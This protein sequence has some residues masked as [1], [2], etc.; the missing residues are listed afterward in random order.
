MKNLTNSVE[1]LLYGYEPG[2]YLPI[3]VNGKLTNKR[4]FVAYKVRQLITR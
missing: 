3:R 2:K 4:T 1:L